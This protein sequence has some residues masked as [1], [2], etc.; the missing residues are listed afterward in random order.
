MFQPCL[1]L[2]DEPPS[3]VKPFAN[4]KS[5]GKASR[6]RRR[7]ESRH[8]RRGKRGKSHEEKDKGKQGTDQVVSD[9]LVVKTKEPSNSNSATAEPGEE[10]EYCPSSPEYD[11]YHAPRSRRRGYR[12]K[13]PKLAL[14]KALE[15]VKTTGMFSG[16]SPARINAYKNRHENPNA[17]YYRFNEAG[18][19][20]RNGQ[21]TAVCVFSPL[22]SSSLSE[23]NDNRRG[24]EKR[25]EKTK[26]KRGE[27]RKRRER[28]EEREEREREK[29]EREERKEKIGIKDVYH[30]QCSL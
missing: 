22:C 1:A 21:W 10:A 13:V 19:T 17:Y 3:P 24:R 20:Q 11:E 16:W 7:G 23:K 27:R 15:T 12:R 9:C 29:A 6:K 4:S 8:A 5:K 18:E 2:A 28:R 14:D 25:E 26:E 30:T